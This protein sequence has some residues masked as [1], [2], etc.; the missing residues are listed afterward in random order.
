MVASAYDIDSHSTPGLA[1]A[2]RRW[3][4][5]EGVRC[6]LL[7]AGSPEELAPLLVWRCGRTRPFA[8]SSPRFD[9]AYDLDMFRCVCR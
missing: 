6:E 3:K 4:G 5:A 1:G 7:Q 8:R 9:L 2:G